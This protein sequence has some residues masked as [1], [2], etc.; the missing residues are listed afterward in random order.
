MVVVVARSSLGALASK[1]DFEGRL[2][3]P[4]GA[5]VEALRVFD[6]AM[7]AAE[8]S[9][10]LVALPRLLE[11]LRSLA[12][13]DQSNEDCGCIMGEYDAV[14]EAWRI[15][16]EGIPVRVEGPEPGRTLRWRPP[17]DVTQVT[18]AAIGA[19][20]DDPT[21]LSA[22]RRNTEFH[23]ERERE[24]TTRMSTLCGRG[25]CGLVTAYL[26]GRDGKGVEAG[27]PCWRHAT[28]E[29]AERIIGAYRHAVEA[30]ACPGCGALAG[31]DCS[32]GDSPN[33]KLRPVDGTWPHIRKF[34]GQAVHDVRLVTAQR[35]A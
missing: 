6:Q 35:L 10:D 9:F 25:G 16:R 29:E 20:A 11:D 5:L 7:E 19:R 30:I 24:K 33:R 13:C 1:F 21:Y 8:E 34:R 23:Q 2:V 22:C 17:L 31:Q 15:V 32:T 14:V 28:D 27:L 18:W 4:I 26:P 12:P 3:G